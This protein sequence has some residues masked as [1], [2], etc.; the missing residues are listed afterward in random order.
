MSQAQPGHGGV[1]DP[2]SNKI[3]PTPVLATA[4]FH[5]FGALTAATSPPWHARYG[6]TIVGIA[7]DLGTFGLGEGV[8]FE[9]QVNG[10]T[11]STITLASTSSGH[12]A[13]SPPVAIKA[14]TDLVTV[15]TTAIGSGSADLVVH[16][17]LGSV[18]SGTPVPVPRS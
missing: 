11:I 5:M 10:T 6:C 8:T 9:V 1:Y 17:E 16:V 3:V 18:V 4:L 12:T 14:Y 15:V 13:V 7:A 2:V